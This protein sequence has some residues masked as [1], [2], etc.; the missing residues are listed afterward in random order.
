MFRHGR[1]AAKFVDWVRWKCY[2]E[3]DELFEIS[4]DDAGLAAFAPIQPT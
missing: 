3:L 2:H 4:G 1:Q